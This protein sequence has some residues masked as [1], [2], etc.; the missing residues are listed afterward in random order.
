MDDITLKERRKYETMWTLIDD[1]RIN[2]PADVLTPV[3]LSSFCDQIKK[4]ETVL[5]FGCGPGRSVFPLLNFGLNVHLIDITEEALDVEIFLK[6]MKSSICFTESCL[7]DLP[8]ELKPAEWMLCLDVLEHIPEEKLET[9]LLGISSRMLKGGLFSISLIE[10]QFG[11][12]I[13]DKLH[14]TIRSADWWKG[15]ISQFFGLHTELWNNESLLVLLVT[16]LL[17]SLSKYK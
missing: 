7:W 11:Q 9:V 14:L 4:G 10:D 2:S 15:K 12:T 8:S 3:F 17:S 6:Y 1:Y 13:G 5:D 16:D